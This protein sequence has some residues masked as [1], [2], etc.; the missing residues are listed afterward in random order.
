M[1]QS[2]RTD[3]RRKAPAW[4]ISLLLIALCL[5]L[6]GCD[7]RVQ[8]IPTNSASSSVTQT[9]CQGDD[10]GG[11]RGVKLFVEPDAGEKVIL[12]AINSAKRSIWVKVYLLTNRNVIEALKSAAKH[13]KDVRVLLEE[14]PYGGGN[15]SPQESMS[16]LKSAGVQGKFTDPKFRF[17]HEKSMVIDGSVAYIL[18]MNLTES[19]LGERN[20]EYGIIDTN[21]ADVQTVK[22]LFEADWQRTKASLDN[23]RV[24]ASPINSRDTFVALIRNAHETL[25]IEAETMNDEE[26]EQELMDAAKRGVNVQIVLPNSLSKGDLKDVSTLKRG[27]V[28]VRVI[29]SPYMHAKIIIADGQKAFVGSVN[30]STTSFDKNRELGIVIADQDVLKTLYQ[31]F[32][33]DWAKAS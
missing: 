31:T 2:Y 32:Q 14:H 16:M 24:V 26:I 10:C 17:T 8:T 21:P 22:G 25:Q 33:K 30:I 28:K 12:D 23:P 27:K 15:L 3:S 6:I 20:R 19:A 4:L 18:T 5:L 9:S 13:G 7:T 1:E 29:G 11:A